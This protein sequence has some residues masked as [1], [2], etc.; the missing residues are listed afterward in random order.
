M[1]KL[2]TLLILLAS[3][4]A[5]AQNSVEQK[6]QNYLDVNYS[7]Y[8]LI[9]NDVQEWTIE[10]TA[11][12]KATKITNYYIKQQYQGI[13]IFRAVT[14]V[15][16]K[17][18]AVINLGNRFLANVEDKI[19]T[20]SAGIGV[21]DGF[22][23][24]LNATGYDL[25]TTSVIEKKDANNYV[26]SNGNL[27]DEPVQAELVFANLNDGQTLKLAWDYTFFAQDHNHY[28]S[29]RVDAVSGDVLQKE[30][31]TISCNFG[32]HSHASVADMLNAHAKKNVFDF[33]K[34]AAVE[35]NSYMFNPPSA[36]YNV[37]PF[38][39]E[40][41]NHGSRQLLTNPENLTASPY[42]WHD[43]NGADG[44]EYTI[45]RGN[46]VLAQDDPDGDNGTGYS[47]DAGSTL[48]FD[49]TYPGTSVQASNYIDAAVTNLFYMNNI[50]HD[51]TYHYGFDEAN[52]NFQKNNY[53]NGGTFS[54]LGD[55]VN[56]DAQD[57]AGT[58]NA[59]FSTPTDGNNPRM[60]MYLWTYGPSPKYLTINAPSSIAGE[61]VSLDNVF[62]PGHVD[63]PASPSG[64]TAD[65]VL[66]DD[67]VGSDTSDACTA[68][69]NA[70]E[71]NG[72]IAVI[73]RGDCTFISK[74][75][76]AQNAGAIG[77]IM[78]NNVSYAEDGENDYAN[79]SG[80]DASVTIPAIFVSKVDGEAI[81]AAM[82]NGSVTVNGTLSEPAEVFIESDG[83]FDN[84]VIAHEYG[85]GVSTRLTG[86]FGNSSCLYNEEQMGEG[87]SDWLGYMLQIETGDT[88]TD[89]RGVSTF[90][91]G[92][93]TDGVGIR[94]YPYS[95]DFTV[96]PLTFGDTNNYTYTYDGVTYVDVHSVGT[97]WASMLWDLTWAYI[98]K[99]GFDSDI[100]NGT[101][102]NNKVFQLVLDAMKLQPC[103]PGFVDG[104]DAIIA[105]DLATTGGEDYCLIW[106]VFANRGLGVNASSG[107]TDSITDQ[108][109]DFTEPAAGSNC[110]FL[111]TESFDLGS[112][113]SIYPNPSTG[114][115][116]I[117]IA[118]FTGDVEVTVFDTNGRIVYEDIKTNFSAQTQ[119]NLSN[120][121]KGMYIIQ[122]KADGVQ[123]VN[124]LMKN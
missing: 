111:K 72:N 51:I 112:N 6:I 83:D 46:N 49:Y 76:A 39:V 12:S 98:E 4:F 28:W 22:A 10:S 77:V 11:T 122:L 25:F 1:K 70:T 23:I 92:Q 53:G 82:S 33:E 85:H 115:F 65:L 50:V 107:S 24:A 13:D 57:G 16:Y 68:A 29:I 54:F 86:G 21:T 17:D 61:I 109:E 43:I 74:V 37:L 31:W 19:N 60:Q 91:A 47:P 63:L 117:E 69:V 27:T 3:V 2:L 95:T 52:G 97:V 100:Y 104:R 106:E 71:L 66:F 18:D 20:T 26:L 102:G 123:Y 88:G 81:I 99:Y 38:Y 79:M 56:A 105:A 45:T 96:D 103:S 101:G 14:N 67:G 30:D 62:D 64:I 113:V 80:A 58:N 89:Y 9:F 118:D 8:R 93:E 119:I 42:G 120:V 55:Y 124:K 35:T 40:S 116:N 84:L 110:T 44:A 73:R 32:D 48:V 94:E 121:D 78:V 15:S 5:F 75:L 7:T 108:T 90:L 59:N 87:W 114:V 34:I 36:T 41:P